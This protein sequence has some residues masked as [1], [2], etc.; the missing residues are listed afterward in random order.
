MIFE[1]TNVLIWKLFCSRLL[2]ISKKY[3]LFEEGN[4]LIN[5]W[6]LLLKTPSGWKANSQHAICESNPGTIVGVGSKEIWIKVR[7]IK[8][9]E[10]NWKGI[11]TINTNQQNQDCVGAWNRERTA[12]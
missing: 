7:K 8:A 11:T 9:D 12:N 1:K 4:F 5:D 3:G 2:L 10:L 6:K